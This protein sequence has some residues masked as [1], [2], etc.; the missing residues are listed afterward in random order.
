MKLFNTISNPESVRLTR[1]AAAAMDFIYEK[2]IDRLK[3][4]IIKCIVMIVVMSGVSLTIEHSWTSFGFSVLFFVLGGSLL[5]I[6]HLL[7]STRFAFNQVLEAARTATDWSD[8]AWY[9]R[10]SIPLKLKDSWAVDLLHEHGKEVIVGDFLKAC[11][12]E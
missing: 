12:P 5:Y 7:E 6:S 2:Q 3:Q 9:M 8:L 4:P 1:E 11:L 10:K